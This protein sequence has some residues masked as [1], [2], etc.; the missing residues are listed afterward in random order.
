MIWE[1][2]HTLYHAVLADVAHGG[3]KV[4]V[5]IVDAGSYHMADPYGLANALQILHHLVGVCAM[6]CR[7]AVVQLIVHG[8]YVKKDEIRDLQKTA[9]GIVEYNTTGVQG[10]MY[11]LLTAEAEVCLYEWS[12]NKWFATGAGYTSCL[13]EVAIAQSFFQQL[14]RSP[15][16]LDR[17]LEV[18]CVWVVAE[19]ATHGAALHEGKET[20]TR[21]VYRAEG[22]QGVDTTYEGGWSI[23]HSWGKGILGTLRSLRS[24]EVLG[25]LRKRG[26]APHLIYIYIGEGHAVIFVPIKP[27]GE[28][29]KDERVCFFVL[30]FI[31]LCSSS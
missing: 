13:D 23:C 25:A 26:H 11:A 6:M 8:L 4:L 19:E 9:H 29:L 21:P 12:L 1:D 28:K 15:F 14:L 10:R 17:G 20:Y 24:L 22:F 30:S 5:V 27:K 3:Q 7:K 18:P 16:V 2:V 31:R